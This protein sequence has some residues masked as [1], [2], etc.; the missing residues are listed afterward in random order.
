MSFFQFSYRRSILKSMA[1]SHFPNRRPMTYA[2]ILTLTNKSAID[3][4]IWKECW[5]SRI[6]LN[7]I[8]ICDNDVSKCE[9]EEWTSICVGMLIW[10]YHIFTTVQVHVYRG[11]K[12][13]THYNQSI[14]NIIYIPY[15]HFHIIFNSIQPILL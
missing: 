1:V 3:L 5:F 6:P 11:V 13:T 12:L 8:V 14:L 15:N 9:F 7:R 4:R 2:L 10:V